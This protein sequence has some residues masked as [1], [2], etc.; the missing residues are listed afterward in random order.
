MEDEKDGPKGREADK[1]L[2]EVTRAWGPMEAELVKNFLESHGISCLIRGRIV[3]FVYPITVDGLG[4]FKV[5]VQDKDFE[6]AKAL[7]MSRPEMGEDPPP[8]DPE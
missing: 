7:L 6:T 2:R 8:E 1:D 5:F 3:P 4:E